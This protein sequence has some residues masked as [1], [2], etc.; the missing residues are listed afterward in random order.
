MRN[1][2]GAIAERAI[3]LFETE[4]VVAMSFTKLPRSMWNDAVAFGIENQCYPV[5]FDLIEYARKIGF[6]L[7]ISERSLTRLVAAE[8]FAIIEDLI[9]GHT[10]LQIRLDTLAGEMAMH[11]SEAVLTLMG[12]KTFNFPIENMR[13]LP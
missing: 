1:H 2:T 13:M 8:Q 3:S 10:L 4:K 9:N 12:N 11:Y 7:G 6:Q 5:V